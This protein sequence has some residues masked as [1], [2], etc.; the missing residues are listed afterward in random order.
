MEPFGNLPPFAYFFW[1]PIYPFAGEPIL[2]NASESFVYDGY[3]TQYEWDWDNDGEY[4]ESH[5]IPTTTHVFEKE[6][7]Y[8]VTLKV[9]DNNSQNDMK[10]KVI[11]VKFLNNPPDTPEIDGP[12]SGKTGNKYE[13]G[14][15]AVDP[16]KDDVRYHIDWGDNT[17]E[18]T[19]FNQS[20]IYVNVSHIWDLNGVYTITAF[21][22]DEHGLIGPEAT[23][24][25]TMP[26]NKAT[27][28]SLLLRFLEQFP[29]LQKLLLLIN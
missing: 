18:M 9:L 2:F 14:F 16:D 4:D 25:V 10:T 20:G 28:S 22:E 8:Y 11:I 21:A 24:T 27:T 29:I 13:F 5:T 15:N 17:S 26:R 19:G 7:K 3:I 1:T 6:G 23:K 12:N